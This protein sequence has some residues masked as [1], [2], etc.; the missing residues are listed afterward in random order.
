MHAQNI[1]NLTIYDRTGTI[2]FPVH[3]IWIEKASDIAEEY[4][5]SFTLDRS[6]KQHLGMLSAEGGVEIE[7]VAVKNPHAISKIWIDPAEGLSDEALRNWVK[8][9][10][11]NPKAEEGVVDILRKLY[12]VYIKGDASLAE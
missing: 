7:D 4:Y 2:G 9:A 11:L 6:K 8:G 12:D 5:A 1:L 3:V 10:K